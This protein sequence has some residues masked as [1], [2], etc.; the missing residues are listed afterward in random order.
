MIP[1]RT[2]PLLC[3]Q[4][5]E[6]DLQH[7]NSNHSRENQHNTSSGPPTG[8]GKMPEAPPPWG[9]LKREWKNRT[10][11]RNEIVIRGAQQR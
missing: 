2:S 11:Y 5:K 4:H 1:G 10:R 7:R 9:I 8:R 3:I 6:T